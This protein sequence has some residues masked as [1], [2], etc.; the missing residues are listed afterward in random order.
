M[1]I[2][3]GSVYHFHIDKV[4]DDGSLYS[5][6]RFFIILNLDPKNDKTLI[7]VTITKEVDKQRKFAVYTGEDPKTIVPI[8]KKDFPRLSRDSV[9]NCNRI[10]PTNLRELIEKI[11]NGGKIF[12]DKLP[13]IIVNALVSGVLNSKRVLPEHKAYLA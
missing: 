9:V 13:K 1:C 7:T 11:E 5:G 12:S 4:N 8:S 6:D 10:Y 2:E 3:R